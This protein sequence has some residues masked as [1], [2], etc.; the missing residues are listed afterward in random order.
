MA[1]IVWSGLEELK[2]GLR[3]LPTELGSEGADIVEAR[4]T[5]AEA[6]IAAGYPART[7]NLRDKLTVEHARSA[8]GARSVVRNTSKHA[9]PFE[10]GSQVNRYTTRGV[11]R[12]RMPANHLFTQTIMRER[13]AMDDDHKALLVRHGLLVSGDA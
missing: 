11:N 13:R 8:F 4:A 6:T 7:G 1:A 10:I 5:R 3:A 2:A 9:V 12:G